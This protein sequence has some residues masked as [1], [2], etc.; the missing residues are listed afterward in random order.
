MQGKP[1]PWDNNQKE[2]LRVFISRIWRGLHS[3]FHFSLGG[4]FLLSSG[5]KTANYVPV[6]KTI[7]A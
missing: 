5:R 2:A 4:S 6:F 7:D 1:T 3:T